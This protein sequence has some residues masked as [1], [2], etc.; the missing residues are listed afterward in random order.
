MNARPLRR[1]IAA[2]LRSPFVWGQC[3]CCLWVCDWVALMR[4]VDP[5][6][7]FRGS[8]SDAAG[9]AALV[10]REGGLPALAARLAASAG[11]VATTDPQPGAAALVETRVGPALMLVT[12]LRSFA[13]KSRDGVLFAR[14]SAPLAA[15]SV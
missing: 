12:G 7:G 3:D 2:G 9:C 8:Y 1:F 11:L 14:C 5:G 15:W 6:K 10:E 13:W 4:G